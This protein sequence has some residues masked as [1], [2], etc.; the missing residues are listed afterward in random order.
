VKLVTTDERPGRVS[1]QP[2]SER[3]TRALSLHENRLTVSFISIGGLDQL[4]VS[5]GGL[6]QRS[7]SI[8]GLD[9][10]S[11]SIGG[12]DQRYGHEAFRD[13]CDTVDV[14]P[15][16]VIAPRTERHRQGVP[17]L[18]NYEERFVKLNVAFL[19]IYQ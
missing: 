4:S 2:T 3:K 17:A 6:D 5:I 15:N 18:L 13:N 11:V 14:S 9:Q 10:R 1:N 7:V 19:Q 8:G 16:C 12:L